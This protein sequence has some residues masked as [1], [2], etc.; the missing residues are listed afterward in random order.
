VVLLLD[1]RTIEDAVPV[2][3]VRGSV[4]MAETSREKAADCTSLDA[5]EGG[6]VSGAARAPRE[7]G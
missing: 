2:A 6:T 7:R 1:E 4:T 3:G 5:V